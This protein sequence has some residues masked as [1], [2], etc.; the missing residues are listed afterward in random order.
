MLVER[1]NN[2]VA[3]R[4]VFTAGGFGCVGLTDVTVTVYGPNHSILVAADSPV[5]LA[6]GIYEYVLAANLT[7]TAGV[8]TAVAKT[9]APVDNPWAY[10]NCYIG[11][12]GLEDIGAIKLKTDNIG[13]GQITTVAAVAQSGSVTLVTGDDYLTADGRELAFTDASS[14]WPTLTGA[15]IAF[16]IAG[17]AEAPAL[18]TAAVLTVP[19]AA[20]VV[21]VDLTAARTRTLLPGVYGYA[22]IATLVGGSVI[23]LCRG[24]MLVFAADPSA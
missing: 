23:T 19:G 13:T 5:E 9:S 16:I 7:G 22:I 2:A 20:Q 21:T 3:L 24:H 18:T 6:N 15:S 1:I 10:A 12:A 4:F 14:T 8:Y 17:R 11:T